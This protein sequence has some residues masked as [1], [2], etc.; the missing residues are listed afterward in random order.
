MVLPLSKLRSI[1]SFRT[2]VVPQT[3]VRTSVKATARSNPPC[4]HKQIN[5]KM[6]TIWGLALEGGLYTPVKT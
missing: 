3:A 2:T 1:L 5:Y 4:S 6:L